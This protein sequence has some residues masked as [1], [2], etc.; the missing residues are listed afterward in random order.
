MCG[1]KVVVVASDESGNIDLK[2]LKAKALKHKDHLVKTSTVHFY[3]VDVGKKY[4]YLFCLKTYIIN[5][6]E[7]GHGL[8]MSNFILDYF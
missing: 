1:M 2:D 7:L 8:Q 3:R 5:Y 6:G 4:W